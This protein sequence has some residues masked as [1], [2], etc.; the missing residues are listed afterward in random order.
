[1]T[2]A[3][4]A[5]VLEA[6][7]SLERDVL[8]TRIEPLQAERPP[9]RWQRGDAVAEWK[10]GDGSYPSEL[11]VGALLDSR[12]RLVVPLSVSVERENDEYIA[13]CEVVE[14]FGYGSEPLEAVDDLRRTVA[15]LYWTL[16]GGRDRLA[17]GMERIWQF[18]EHAIQQR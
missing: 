15:E 6:G 9:A 4:L 13:H 17:P 2:Q 12:L 10:S 18:L 7:Q 14:E 3:V 11:L 5:R 1:M 8:T 16:A